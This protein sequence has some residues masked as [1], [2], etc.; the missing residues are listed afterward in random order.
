MSAFQLFPKEVS[1]ETLIMQRYEH[2]DEQMQCQ[3]IVKDPSF[4]STWSN[5]KLSLNKAVTHGQ[6]GKGA[7]DFGKPKGD[8]RS[9]S[10]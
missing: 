2:H 5:K 10:N 4:I 1:M 7:F 3:K 6:S 9:Q 8:F